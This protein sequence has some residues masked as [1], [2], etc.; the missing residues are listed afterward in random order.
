MD[1]TKKTS[2]V[3]FQGQS[4]NSY[5]QD[6]KI[7]ESKSCKFLSLGNNLQIRFSASSFFSNMYAAKKMSKKGTTEHVKKRRLWYL[8]LFYFLL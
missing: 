6:L 1:K 7:F 5:F 8:R 3:D 4:C 2:T